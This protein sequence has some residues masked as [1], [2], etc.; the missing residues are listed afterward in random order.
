MC[1]IAGMLS[2]DPQRPIDRE[3]LERMTSCLAH[4]GPDGSGFYVN[5]PIGFGHRRLSIIDLAGGRQPIA[6]EDRSVWVICNGELYNYVELRRD[7][8]SRG[9]RFTTGSDTEVIVH[10][11]EEDGLDCLQSFRGM[12]AFAVWDEKE[13][14]LLLARDRLGKKPL[15]YS[16]NG[17]RLLFASELQALLAGPQVERPLDPQAV[18]LYLTYGYVPSP[19]SIFSGISKV[20]PAHRLVVDAGGLRV[21]RY[22]RLEYEPKRAVGQEEAGEEFL[23]LFEEAVRIRL[24]SDVPLGAFLSGGLDSSSVVAMMARLS[25]RP[26]KTFSIGFEETEHSELQYARL[27]AKAF[28]TDHHE[29]IVRPDATTVVPML[30][31]HYGDPYADSSALP[32][33][34]VARETRQHVTVALNGDGGDELLAGYPRYLGAAVSLQIDRLPRSAKQIAGWLFSR[35]GAQR[36]TRPTTDRLHRVARFFDAVNSYPTVEARYLR[37]ISTFMPEELNGLYTGEF[38]ALVDGFRSDQF[39]RDLYQERPGSSVIERLMAVDIGSYLPEDLLAK[40]DIAS[41]VHALEVRSP[42]LDHRLMEYAA[43][44]PVHYK[45]SGLTTKVLLRQVMDGVLPRAVL[46]RS[47]MGFGIPLGRWLQRELNDWM[48]QVLL[49]PQARRRGIFQPEVVRRLIEEHTTGVCDHRYRL[50]ALLMFELWHQT[51][52]DR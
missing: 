30:V 31:R 41:M 27:V 23:S 46:R 52:L 21:E 22:W 19:R 44:L 15:W 42:F 14:R 6:N 18:D 34:Y 11:Y 47:K 9:H 4:R 36:A 32:T 26:V 20:P 2:F 49:D 37:W 8:E 39:I 40:V 5:G 29:F 35:M 28:G 17:H 48:K 10:Q 7:L 38:R 12:F 45:A 1:G 16:A 43:R 3:G 50:W 24:R 13:R 25:D 51:F 33:F